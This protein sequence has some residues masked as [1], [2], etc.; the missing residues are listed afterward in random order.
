M[1]DESKRADPICGNCGNP[2]SKHY[3]EFDQVYCNATTNGDIYTTEAP[4]ELI[5]EQLAELHQTAYD[6]LANKWRRDNGHIDIEAKDD[7]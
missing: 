7:E 5:L 1:S 4:R 6:E 3:F 2:R